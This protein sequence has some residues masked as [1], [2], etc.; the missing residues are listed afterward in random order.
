[1]KNANQEDYPACKDAFKKLNYKLIGR[2]KNNSFYELSLN[3]D[4]KIFYIFGYIKS[5]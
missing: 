3:F 5:N 1:M 4:S 2:S